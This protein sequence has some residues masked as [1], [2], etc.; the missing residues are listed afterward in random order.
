M[1]SPRRYT[2]ALKRAHG[3]DFCLSECPASEPS[4]YDYVRVEHP[5]DIPAADPRVI[6]VAI[7][8][9]NHGWPNLGHDSLV[10]VV[11]DA[12]CDLASVMAEA[13]LRMRALSYEVRK[14][15][16]VPEAPGGRF[17][18]YMGT[19][20]P[21]HID[22]RRNDG[23][24][25]GSQGIDEN[26]GWEGPLFALFD[27]IRESDE[28]ALISVCHSFGVMCRW[29]GAAHPV[30][31]SEAKGGK[32]AGI[33]EN[34]LTAD[35]VRHPWFGQLAEE[36]PDHRRLRIVDHRLFD[37][38][39]EDVLPRGVTAIGY[40]TRGVEGPTGEAVTMIEWERDGAGT[41]PRVFAVNHHPEIVDRTRQMLILRQKLDRGE[42]DQAWFDD[43]SRVLTETYSDD[44]RDQ[45]LHLTSDFTLMGP[46]RYHLY[47]QVRRRAEALGVTLQLHEDMVQ[48]RSRG[49]PAEG[50]GVH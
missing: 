4:V 19:G 26:P 25:E 24:A 18:V 37:L 28:G 22:P 45:R 38:I 29:S 27:R 48:G 14:Q 43:R 40:E 36:L 30:L 41:M 31:R 17:A 13:G 5:D 33:Q 6:D 7:L 46:V 42:V 9:M 21:G 15:H 34:V 39:P 23:V 49:V 50:A 11:K 32:S 35:A 47:R 1:F 3:K 10:H 44:A 2:C 16:M 20:G 8:D 12:A